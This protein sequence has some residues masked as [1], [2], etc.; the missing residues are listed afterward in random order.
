MRIVP[1]LHARESDMDSTMTPMIDVVFLLLVFFVWTSSFHAVETLLPSRLAAQTGG[2]A[3]PPIEISPEFDFDQIVVRVG[4]ED[5]AVS[6]QINE[7]PIESL[8]QLRAALDQIHDVQP[9]APIIVHPAEQTPL[10]HV[11]E[12]YDHA[13]LS[14]FTKVSLAAD[15]SGS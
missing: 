8:E 10:A 2:Q 1:K 5:G 3:A 4:F 15:L 13:R 7:A 9:Q 14:G 12:A 11:I 6:W